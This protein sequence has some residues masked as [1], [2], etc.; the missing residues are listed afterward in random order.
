M[1]MVFEI[2]D[3]KHATP[4]TVSRAGILY[5]STNQGTQWRSL[6]KSFV[7]QR[8]ESEEV[9]QWLQ[10]L[11]D[12]YIA[13]SLLWLLLNVKQVLPL[14][15]MNVVQSMLYMLELLLTPK[16]TDTRENLEVVFNYCAVWALG[17]PLGMSDDG[18]DYRAMMSDY[19][20]SQW[21][22]VKFPKKG[23][24]STVF[25]YYLD[26]KTNEFEPWAKSPYF[27]SIDYDPSTMNM[28]AITVPTSE[29]CSVAFWMTDLVKKHRPVMLAGPS[30]T[31]KT[32]QVNGILKAMD[33]A[34][35]LSATI[36]FN[37][38]TTS[39]VLGN[40]M[41]LPLE[42]KTGTNF[43]PPGIAHLVY[44]VDD[45][46]LPE[47]DKYMTQSAIAL[48][49]QQME[50]G[51][52]YDMTKLAQNPVR[53]SALKFPSISQVELRGDGVEATQHCVDAVAAAV[54]ESTR[55]AR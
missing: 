51:H 23:A 42:K 44:F 29:T 1:R 12:E 35:F 52:I 18:V 20:T 36:N 13:D 41:C 17:G 21:K 37:F 55:L 22:N 26:P 53:D 43:G 9:K 32:Q 27:F 30:G 33:P 31:G 45:L 14:E 39:A 46:N 11:F 28:S 47:V 48:L 54:R 19:W 50:Y 3:L 25:D 2:R 15:D 34:A 24:A 10:E 38:Y 5:I 4:A 7:K 16:N 40:T 49:R 6:I 8:T